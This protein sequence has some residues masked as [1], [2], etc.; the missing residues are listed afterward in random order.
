MHAEA[1]GLRTAATDALKPE[2]SSGRSALEDVRIARRPEE[3]AAR[4]YDLVVIGGGIHGVALAFEAARRGYRPL[5]LER[6]DFGGGTSWSNL[7][8]IHGG[9]RYLQSM[10]L[11]RFRESVA[12]RRWFLQHFPDLIRPLPCLMPL[13]GHGLKRPGFL[14]LALAANDLL[15]LHRDRGLD[16]GVRLPRGR[17]LSAGETPSLR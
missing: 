3:R 15:G 17:V 7:R 11:R 9:L 2:K 14:R 5:L 6:H 10:D 1:T 4:P 13:Y 16:E 12:E 8:I